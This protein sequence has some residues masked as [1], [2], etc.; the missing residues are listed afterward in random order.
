M[1]SG[2]NCGLMFYEHSVY[3]CIDFVAVHIRP[4]V[5]FSD[6]RCIHSSELVYL[7]TRSAHFMYRAVHFMFSGPFELRLLAV[8]VSALI[9]T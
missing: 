4:R 8:Y 1:I 3:L 9:T 6:V 7:S 5:F 2:R